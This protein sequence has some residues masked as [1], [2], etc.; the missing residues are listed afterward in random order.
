[1]PWPAGLV[2]R[3]ETSMLSLAALCAGRPDSFPPE[4]PPEDRRHATSLTSPDVDDDLVL[5]HT[6][7]AGLPSSCPTHPLTSTNSNH[8]A[9]VKML[10]FTVLPKTLMDPQLPCHLSLES[11]APITSQSRSPSTA[12]LSSRLPSP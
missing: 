6:T 10:S 12:P 7:A 2:A 3:M 9:T 11:R 4:C 8:H 5:Q 1:M